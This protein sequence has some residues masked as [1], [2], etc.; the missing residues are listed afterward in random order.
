MNKHREFVV[1]GMILGPWLSACGPTQASHV[2]ANAGRPSQ[3]GASNV[4]CDANGGASSN[5][6]TAPPIDDTT[7]TGPYRF[8]S[9]QI[10]GGGFV[11]GIEFSPI[12]RNLIF[13]RTDVGGAYRWNGDHWMAVTDWIDRA[14]SNLMGIESIAFDPK[15][16]K[17][18]YLAAGMYVTAGNGAILRSSDAGLSFEHYAIP[19]PMGGNVD[20]RSMGERLVVDPQRSE[21]LYFASRTRGLWRSADS[22][23][24][25]STVSSFPATGLANIGL[26]FVLP[27]S[28][29]GNQNEGVSTLYVGVADTAGPSLYRSVDAGAT[30]SP[31]PGTPSGLLP[32]HGKLAKD[33]SLYFVFADAPGPNNVTRGAVMKYSQK[34]GVWTDISP[35]AATKQRFG[36]IALDPQHPGSLVV[37]TIDDWSPDEI[38]RT[39]DDGAHWAALGASA[40]RDP[41]GAEYLR[42]GN[43]SASH[44]ATGWMGDI[45]IDPFDPNRALYITGQGIWWS[46]DVRSCGPTHWA[47]RNQGLEETVPLDLASP[48]AGAQLLSGLGDIGGFRHDDLDAPPS[49]GMYK[50]PVFGNTSGLDFAELM[51]EFVVRVGTGSSRRGAYSLDGGTTWSPFGSEPA[52]SRG[53]GTVAVA[54]DASV[55]VWSAQGAVPSFTTDRGANW[56]ACSGLASGAKVSADRTDPKV[57][58]AISSNGSEFFASH[59]AGATFTSLK[60]DLPRGSA[61]PRAVFGH[62]GDVWVAASNGLYHS[63]AH[64][65]GLAPIAGVTSAYGVSFG[66]AAPGASYP[67]LFVGGNV[68]GKD[69]LFRSDDGGATFTQID[70]TR[71]KYGYLN[72]IAGDP[73]LYGRLYVGTSGRGVLYA[74]PVE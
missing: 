15:D 16:P 43:P 47:F 71:H 51:P 7:P 1:A 35:P 19:T 34:T 10:L 8:R 50:N 49:G 42:F 25:W 27:D 44:S 65:E 68:G 36:G 14:S 29:T 56:A 70:D 64:G 63:A 2:D 45:E 21:V 60:R 38:Y 6:L 4:A 3:A 26:S 9:V 33:G 59:D 57:F 5:P 74:D 41:M 40:I 69:G 53:Q 20:G 72:V 22:G 52:S 48:P 62:A 24:S 61:R 31:V 58:Y 11:T 17:V 12:E 46:D 18:V 13:A 67:A 32:H 30:W 54:A 39:S 37:T 55:I 28:S 23:R 66:K 73:K